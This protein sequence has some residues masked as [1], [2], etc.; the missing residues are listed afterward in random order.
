MN[1]S[2]KAGRRRPPTLS[3]KRHP[4]EK[5]LAAIGNQ[6]PWVDIK[7]NKKVIGLIK[8]PTAFSQHKGFKVMLRVTESANACGWKWVTLKYE[9]ENEAAT[10]SFLQQETEA[11]LSKF[12]LSP[13]EDE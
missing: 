11:L 4:R 2:A 8:P 1:I 10:R 9:G 7:L 5:G 6:H 3:F 12:D 13:V